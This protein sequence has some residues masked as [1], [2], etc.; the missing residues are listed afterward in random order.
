M[1][2]GYSMDRSFDDPLRRARGKIYWLQNKMEV[3]S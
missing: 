2:K 3:G 1:E